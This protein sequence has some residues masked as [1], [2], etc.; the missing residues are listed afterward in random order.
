MQKIHDGFWEKMMRP[1]SP[2]GLHI[3][4]LQYQL[5]W[6]IYRNCAGKVSWQLQNFRQ[7]FFW[8][9]SWYSNYVMIGTSRQFFHFFFQRIFTF[10]MYEIESFTSENSEN[11]RFVIYFADSWNV[12]QDNVIHIFSS[13]TFHV[14]TPKDVT[15]FHHGSENL[16]Q[17]FLMDSPINL[18]YRF[19]LAK[20]LKMKTQIFAAY[21]NFQV[22]HKI[23]FWKT[24][25]F[26]HLYAAIFLYATKLKLNMLSI[27]KFSALLFKTE[28]E[29]IRWPP[30]PL[31]I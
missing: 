7:T 12:Q 13:G 8:Q 5:E 18:K 3:W 14:K 15:C 1:R 20:L 27:V 16:N 21:W 28:F 11:S 6:V 10:L 4:K 23:T 19:I 24:R 25:K 17:I 29:I 30:S 2:Q 22:F 31:W 26:L 9:K